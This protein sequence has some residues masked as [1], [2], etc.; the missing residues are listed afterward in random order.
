MNTQLRRN[1][2][3]I[4]LVSND[5]Y[6][7]L[8]VAATDFNLPKISLAPMQIKKVEIYKSYASHKTDIILE[9][10]NIDSHA[11]ALW[12]E[13]KYLTHLNIAPDTVD[14]ST[15]QVEGIFMCY[16]LRRQD[17]DSAYTTFGSSP[18]INI[19][20]VLKSITRLRLELENNFVFELGGKNGNS[21]AGSSKSP[22]DFLRDDLQKLY[23][24]NYMNEGNETYSPWNLDYCDFLDP[25]HQISTS[26]SNGYKIHADNNFEA[27]EF[28][29]KQYPLVNTPYDWLLDDFSTDGGVHNILRVADLAWWPTWDKYKDKFKDLS[30]MI[31]ME[32]PEGSVS[33][34]AA[35]RSSAAL[36]FFEVQ[37]LEH[38]PYFDWVEFYVKNGYSKIWATDISSGKP[39]PMDA[40]NHIHEFSRV[41]TPTG[42]VKHIPN[43]VYKEYLTFM[44]E[45]EI[46]ETHLHLNMFQGLNPALEK[47]SI[48]DLHIGDVDIHTIIE[49]DAKMSGNE[50]AAFDRLGMGYQV[51]HT[52]Y[53]QNLLP[54]MFDGSV[55]T[56]GADKEPRGSQFTFNYSMTSEIVFLTIDKGKTDITVPGM[57]DAAYV[58]PA[59]D[60]VIQQSG[61]DSCYD[62]GGGSYTG[63]GVDGVGIPGN[64]SIADQG[65]AMIKTRFRYAWGGKRSAAAGL[66][67]S[68]FTNLA[69]SR[70]GIAYPHGT[71]NQRPWCQ[72]SA[73]ATKI[74]GI[75][76]VK[77]GDILFFNWGNGR[78]FGHT[79]LAISNT[80]FIH[81]SG[82]KSGGKGASTR[83]FAS[84][85]PHN[86]EIYRLKEN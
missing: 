7:Q 24:R 55:S 13:G 26:P 64:T 30:R 40:W 27:L 25:V 65:E 53:R 75:Q 33:S 84:Y 10:D 41:L 56:A 12:S 23:N 4:D 80:E 5:Y 20:V 85:H 14:G 74:S 17:A 68:G 43:P 36:R 47:F 15:K 82:G 52:Y 46:A 39:I 73:N 21:P 50:N 35:F 66:D 29:F 63:G 11:A 8:P 6:K 38:M 22:I 62:S 2:I 54:D 37:K 61:T 31:N 76:N 59:T 83:T 19:R 79:G 48:S 57:E 58:K 1:R 44:T 49:L 71:A 42:N 69:V 9:L 28:F 67:C 3:N 60:G 16:D 51:L 86:T 72:K 18:T 45:Q 78:S 77:R 70:T 81:S 34:E 32:I